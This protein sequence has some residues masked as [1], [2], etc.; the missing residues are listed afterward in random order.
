MKLLPGDS[1][2]FTAGAEI[3][4]RQITDDLTKTMALLDCSLSYRHRSIQLSLDLRN[5]LNQKSYSY[6]IYSTVNTFTYDYRLRGRELILTLR[7]TL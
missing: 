2:Q 5:L 6:T 4:R 3:S 1:F 7:F